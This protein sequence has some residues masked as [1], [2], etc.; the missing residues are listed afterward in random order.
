MAEPSIV[1]ELGVR[2]LVA[3]EQEDE[4]GAGTPERGM[5]YDTF[6]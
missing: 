6:K 4:L 3:L 2:E 5:A 1:G